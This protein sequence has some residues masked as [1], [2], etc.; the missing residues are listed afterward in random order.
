MKRSAENVRSGVASH[1]SV[2]FDRCLSRIWNVAP[3][4]RGTA[5]CCAV[6]ANCSVRGADEF[7]DRVEEALTFSSMTTNVR[8]RLSGAVELEG[9]DFQQPA[10]ALIRS[11]G[12]QLFTPRL[13]VFID[14]QLGARV[15]VFVQTR[16]DRGFD[17]GIADVRARLDEYAV[18]FTP[19][20]DGRFNVQ[21]GKFATVVGN[22]AARHGGWNNPF[23]SAP[24]PYEYLTGIWDTEAVR[25]SSMLLQWSHVRAGLPAS[26]AANEKLMRVPIIWGPSYATGVAVSGDVGRFRYAAE[27]KLGSL[28][29]RPEA[30]Q[31]GREQRRHPTVSTRLG[32]RPNQMFNFG[33]SASSGSYLREFSQRS[34]PARRGRGDYRQL[35]LAQDTSFAWHHWQLWTEI[36]ASR[37]EI[38]NVGN[39]DT[40]AYYTEAKYKFTPRFSGAVRWNQQLFG[41]IVD[42]GVQTRWGN[43]AW[44]ID[45]APGFRFTSHTQLKFEYSLQHGDSR[46]RDYTRL[47][48]VQLT[49]RF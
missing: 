22:W 1:H 16:I 34:V 13:V 25:T 7:L 30:W 44:R 23:I 47:M 12:D 38:P 46:T 4:L 2:R 26:V 11:T 8:A 33:V 18:R 9:Y 17:P 37:F 6:L 35:V 31:R 27:A 19:W 20:R 32:Y 39:A 48:A 29:S 10:P 21:V 3:R 5:L 14:A 43:G 28:S 40:L 36:Y 42:R 15:Y 49:V 45:V 41:T 24:L